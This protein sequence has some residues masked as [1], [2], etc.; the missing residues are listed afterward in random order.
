[1]FGGARLS[2]LKVAA[3]PASLVNCMVDRALGAPGIADALGLA[4]LKELVLDACSL[5][6]TSAPSAVNR[7]V[8]KGVECCVRELEKPP[9]H[10]RAGAGLRPNPK[11]LR[12]FEASELIMCK[13]K[14][15]TQGTPFLEDCLFLASSF[16]SSS[17][18][19]V[20]KWPSPFGYV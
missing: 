16:S 8:G 15:S 19:R 7:E 12:K 6:S 14:Q 13:S 11:H 20:L 5:L 18:A 2:L 1:M 10:R 9:S 3:G 4:Q 17:G